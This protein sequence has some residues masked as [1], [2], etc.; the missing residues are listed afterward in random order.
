[1]ILLYG[2]LP[3][4]QLDYIMRHLNLDVMCIWLCEPYK[5]Y[6]CCANMASLS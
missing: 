5:E 2:L 1:M 3:Y 6:L 4:W